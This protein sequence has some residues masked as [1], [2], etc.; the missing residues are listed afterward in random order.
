MGTRCLREQFSPAVVLHCRPKFANGLEIA[1]S[2]RQPRRLTMHQRSLLSHQGDPFATLSGS[3][4]R[5]ALASNTLDG[6][7]T[8]RRRCVALQQGSAISPDGDAAHSQ[9]S[10]AVA[11]STAITLG[12]HVQS[13][14]QEA[15]AYLYLP[16]YIL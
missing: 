16:R 13:C 10:V 2:T 7:V 8:S 1:L 6:A 12:I 5:G 9:Y 15:W 4:W 14:C 11:Y 3:R